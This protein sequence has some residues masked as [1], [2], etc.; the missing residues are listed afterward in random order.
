GDSDALFRLGIQPLVHLPS[1]GRNLSDHPTVGNQWM[2]NGN[3][4]FENLGRNATL[5]A[6]ILQQWNST[7][8]GVLVVGTFNHVGW[9]QL[10]SNSSIF[11]RFPNP[12]AGPH[13]AHFELLPRFESSTSTFSS[14]IS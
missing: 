11:Q 4:T 2:V 8:T 13:T 10:P 6:E 1:V 12:S 3:D 9:V 7:K 5:A 14:L